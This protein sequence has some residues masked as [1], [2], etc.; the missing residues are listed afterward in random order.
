MGVVIIPEK[1]MAK[2]KELLSSFSAIAVRE[3][4]GRIALQS[5]V[6]IPIQVVVDPTLLLS[7]SDWEQYVPMIKN[8]ESYVL[9]YFLTYNASYFSAV[10]KY[11]HEHNCKLYMFYLN[12]SYYKEADKMIMG[13]PLDFLS[14]M[15]GAKAFFTDSFH[16]TIFSTIFEVPFY[17][18]ERF[19]N[20]TIQNQN[21][22]IENLLSLMGAQS[23]LFNEENM[24][25]IYKNEDIDFKQYKENLNSQICFSKQYLAESFSKF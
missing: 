1:W 17:T 21:S 4:T 11:A 19:K 25:D 18:F 23:R 24:S 12:P 2:I 5:I 13:G 14:Y 3:E 15:K 22:R 20:E 8:E 9:A 7:K 6:D 10:R 16:G